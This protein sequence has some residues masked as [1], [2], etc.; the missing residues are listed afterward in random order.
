MIR[1]DAQ[2]AGGFTLLELLVALF[3]FALVSVMAYSGLRAV[4]SAKDD[5]DA[6]ATRL[7]RLQK[8]YTIMQSDFVQAIDRP[9]R[10]RLGGEVAAMVL[11]DGTLAFTR[12]GRANPLEVTRSTLVRVAYRLDGNRLERL[13]WRTLDRPQQPEIDTTPLLKRVNGL[14]FEFMGG[15]GRW[16]QDWPPLTSGTDTSA[17]PRAIRVSMEVAGAGPIQWIFPLPF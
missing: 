12:D 16:V 8:A 9:I 10:D 13:Q 6:S 4:L 17:L 1:V 5:T 11:R 3:I 14:R 7:T 2:R 15:D